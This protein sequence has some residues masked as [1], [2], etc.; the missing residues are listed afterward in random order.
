MNPMNVPIKDFDPAFINT[1]THNL[2]GAQTLYYLF[3]IWMDFPSQSVVLWCERDD[4]E[5]KCNAIR[6]ALSKERKLR[7]IPRTFEL[8]FSETWPYTYNG[9][10]GQAVKI[11]RIGG[12]IRT[13]MRAAMLEMSMKGRS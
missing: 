10:K 13:R 3:N 12:S 8:R 11:E 1:V 2:T 9:I 5:A 4:A 6:V 7:S